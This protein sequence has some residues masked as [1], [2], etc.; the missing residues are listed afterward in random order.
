MDNTIKAMLES[1]NESDRER[2]TALMIMLLSFERQY[3]YPL[4]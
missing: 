4:G 1:L 2:I 3:P